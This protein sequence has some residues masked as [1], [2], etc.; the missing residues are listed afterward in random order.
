[1][2][3]T[4]FFSNF[5]ELA[6]EKAALNVDTVFSRL[7]IESKE[8]LLSAGVTRTCCSV[9]RAVFSNGPPFLHTGLARI[10]SQ[11]YERPEAES[12]FLID[13]TLQLLS[14]ANLTIG[15]RQAQAPGK[16]VA[17]NAGQNCVSDCVI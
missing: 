8:L 5:E 17:R 3:H 15:K 10:G 12:H 16:Q 2:A 14:C 9:F 7:E 11:I 13:L 6:Q 1:M 4:E